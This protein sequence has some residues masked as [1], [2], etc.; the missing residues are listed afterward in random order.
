MFSSDI[1]TLARFTGENELDSVFDFPLKFSLIDGVLLGGAPPTTARAALVDN[2]S[3][4][5]GGAQPLGTGLSIWQGRVAFADNHDVWRIRGQLD[6]PFAT[7][8]VMTAVLT[9]G[10]LPA[11]YYGTEQDFNGQGGHGSRE[12]MWASGFRQDGP[13]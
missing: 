10:G 13:T 1:H 4:L 5:D 8:L 11:V 7:D 12:V 9:V 3:V 6:D 2:R